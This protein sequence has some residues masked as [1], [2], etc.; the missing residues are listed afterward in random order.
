MNAAEHELET[1]A[2]RD[3]LSRLSEASLRINESLDLDTVL[4]EVV[5]SARALTG[6]AYG[7]ITTLDDSGLPKDF[8]TS[9]LV[10]EAHQALENYLPEGLLVYRYLSALREPLRLDNYG[11]HIASLGLSDF[12]PISASSFLTAPIRHGGR[13]EGNIYL[14]KSE[15]GDEFTQEDE[16]T[17]VMFASHAALVIANARR[18][19]SEQQ[20]RTNLETL[21]D[22][23]PVG[24]AV[25]D[26]KTGAP[27]SFNREAARIVDVL[28]A[29]GRP[30]EQ[31]LE[32]LTFRRADGREISL[33]E[34][35]VAQALNTGETVR[36][37]EVVI[38]VP[39]GRSITTLINATP[40]YSEEGGELESVVVTI[41][42][43]TPLEEIERLRAELLGVVSHELRTPLA[44]I[45][46]SATTMLDDGSALD[47][48]EVRQ[49]H[50]II[51]DQA[52]RMRALISD[53]LDVARIETGTLSISPEP[54]EVAVLVDEARN[55]SLNAGGRN[56]ILIEVPPDLPLVMADRRRIVQV[57]SNLL[58]NAARHSPESSPIR[59]SAVRE[60]VHVAV[61]VADQGSGIPRD[62]MPSLFRKFSRLNAGDQAGDQGSH[63]GLGLSVCKGLVEAHGGR[64]W[65]ESEG[66]GRGARF[67]FTLPLTGETVTIDPEPA[68]GRAGRVP[69]PGKIRPQILV[70]DDDPQ[71]LRYVRDALS[72]AG[73]ATTVTADPAEVPRMMEEEAPQLVL[74]DLMLPDTDG[75]VL[76]QSIREMANVPVIFISAYGQDQIIARAFDMGATDYLVKPFSPTELAAR[77]RAA[78][79][80]QASPGLDVPGEP[81][82]FADLAVDY[83]Q[84]VVTIAG[85]PVDL[86]NIE[87]RLLTELSANAGRV[88]TNEQLRRRVWGQDDSG[89]S[90]P[91][92]A[93]VRRLRRKLGDDAEQPTYIF[94]KR[95]VGYWME[96]EE[97]RDQ[98]Q[99]PWTT[100][101]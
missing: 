85:A 49:F 33:E 79:R 38:Q 74:L 78:L 76:M 96:K 35:P 23:S 92:R 13:A 18:H 28:Q 77:I 97:T 43:M 46:G 83:A 16:E 101:T 1:A 26:A 56:N 47:P 52:D 12:L 36:A 69:R 15:P 70:V 80:R 98:Y 61:S 93:V 14:A 42:D 31:I 54:A 44:A 60:G 21:I 22:T 17:L 71:T 5:D 2:L 27:V 30:P 37:E 19:R 84:R 11:E 50:R 95:R 63:T 58:T 4:Q 3:R 51:V 66:V 67:T 6:S 59:V 48:A 55:T 25:F 8:V 88:L 73:Y 99:Q 24:V 68:T 7:V 34:F 82:L 90:G 91:V 86:T 39:D 41:Q 40:I 75:I 62:R 64:I 29:P 20:A 9:G 45:R 53:L 100:L 94:N 81:Y 65:A 89:G 10:P 87:Y 72:K 32:V 57:L